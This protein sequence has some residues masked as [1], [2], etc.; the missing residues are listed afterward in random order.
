[1]KRA[2]KDIFRAEHLETPWRAFPDEDYSIMLL[3]PVSFRPPGPSLF[4]RF[5]ARVL[6]SWSIASQF[7][8]LWSIHGPDE[9][10]TQCCVSG[11]GARGSWVSLVIALLLTACAAVPSQEMSDARRALDA[12]REAQAERLAPD[13][14]SRA[15]AS[16][17]RASAALSAGDY[18]AAREMARS[19]RDEAISARLLANAITAAS[20]GIASAR[21][22]GRPWQGAQHMLDEASRVSAQGDSARAR[23]MAERALELTR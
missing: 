4:D 9:M 20:E 21:T 22:A 13:A 12:A 23:Q 11:T 19:A 2:G 17:D 15:S 6:A 1:M 10:T 18:D 8:S 7:C 3:A 5:R 14:V 16:L